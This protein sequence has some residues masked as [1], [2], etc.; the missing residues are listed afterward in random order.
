MDNDYDMDS[1][2]KVRLL[3]N[4]HLFG[5]MLNSMT[6]MYNQLSIVDPTIT[7]AKRTGPA[8]TD[9]VSEA[10]GPATRGRKEKGKEPKLPRIKKVKAEKSTSVPAVVRALL[11]LLP[12]FLADMFLVSLIRE[13]NVSTPNA[14]LPTRVK[15]RPLPANVLLN[16][17]VLTSL[18]PFTI[19]MV[20]AFCF[21][22]SELGSITKPIFP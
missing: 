8:P 17:P 12:I 15:L 2:D 6:T 13:P 10:A 19:P 4:F 22:F 21:D 11:C 7:T 3:A 20:R 9:T 16:A 14:L 1:A 5:A 18:P